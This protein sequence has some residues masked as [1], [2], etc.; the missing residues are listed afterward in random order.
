MRKPVIFALIAATALTACQNRKDRLAFDG[1]YFRSKASKVDK[2]F[3]HIDVSVKPVSA[4]F[5]GALAAGEHEA[6]R[7]CVLNFGTS[8]IIW[9]VG[10]DQKPETYQIQNDTLVLR[11]RCKT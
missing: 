7:Y 4:S 3:Q 6:T 10:P 9:E 5:E 11:G 1:Q 8:E 2:D